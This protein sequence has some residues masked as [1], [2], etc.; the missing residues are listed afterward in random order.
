MWVSWWE[1]IIIAMLP[2]S[3]INNILNWSF[4]YKISIDNNHNIL[5]LRF[6]PRDFYSY[7]IVKT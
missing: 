2:S 3:F 6:Q 1:H 7:T 5:N 4:R